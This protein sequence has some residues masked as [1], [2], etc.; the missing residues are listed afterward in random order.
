[1]SETVRIEIEDLRLV[2][3]YLRNLARDLIYPTRGLDP[4]F[5]HTLSYEGDRAEGARLLSVIERL[6]AALPPLSPDNKQEDG[7]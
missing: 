7:K 5:Y 6:R 4:T 3:G 1:M 2:L